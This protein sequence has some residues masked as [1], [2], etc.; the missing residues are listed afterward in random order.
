M[1]R[2]LFFRSGT[3][4]YITEL[5]GKTGCFWVCFRVNYILVILSAEFF[6]IIG[7]SGLSCQVL[8]FSFPPLTPSAWLDSLLDSISSLGYK[9]AA[10]TSRKRSNAGVAKW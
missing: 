9:Y 2:A 8:G 6:I 7:A 3:F 4:Y 10:F 1:N 5:F